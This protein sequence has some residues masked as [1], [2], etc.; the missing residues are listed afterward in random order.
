M[1]ILPNRQIGPF[2]RPVNDDCFIAP[3]QKLGHRGAMRGIGA[4]G[5]HGGFA[6]PCGERPKN[7]SGI[8]QSFPTQKSVRANHL[9][10]GFERVPQELRQK[11]IR[12]YPQARY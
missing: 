1:R 5:I 6:F 7:F 10:R 8:H 11:D 9:S 3:V 2:L 12:T 4:I